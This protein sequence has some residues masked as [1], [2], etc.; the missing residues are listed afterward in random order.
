MAKSSKPKVP[1]S[2]ED[3]LYISNTELSGNMSRCV[4]DDGENVILH[5]AN[6]DE[7]TWRGSYEDLTYYWTELG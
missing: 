4:F 3:R 6:S 5:E 7:E 1:E 2:K